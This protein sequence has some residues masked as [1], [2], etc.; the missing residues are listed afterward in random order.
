[1][2]RKEHR[3]GEEWISKCIYKDIKKWLML[4]WM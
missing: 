1:M 2:N 4:N 3:I